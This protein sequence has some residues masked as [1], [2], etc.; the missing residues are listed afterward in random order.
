MTSQTHRITNRTKGRLLSEDVHAVDATFEHLT[1]LRVLIEGLADNHE[2]GLW[3]TDLKSIPSVPRISPIDLIYVDQQQRVVEAVELLPGGEEPA[4]KSPAVSALV[5]PF[6]TISATETRVGDQLLIDGAERATRAA[7]AEAAV[8]ERPASEVPVQG[9]AAGAFGERFE[10]LAADGRALPP[11]LLEA[12]A[13][14]PRA[15]AAQAMSGVAEADEMTVEVR[16]PIVSVPEPETAPERTLVSPVRQALTVHEVILPEEAP[17]AEEPPRPKG[18]RKRQKKQRSRKAR[19]QAAAQRNREAAAARQR[20]EQVE[21]ATAPGLPVPAPMLVPPAQITQPAEAAASTGAVTATRAQAGNETSQT[22][23]GSERGKIMAFVSRVLHWLNP[24]VINEEQ[25]GSIRR[26]AKDLVAYVGEKGAERKLEVDNISSSGVYVRTEERWEP[27]SEVTLS[28]QQNGPV[29]E[30]PDRHVRVEA[31]TVWHGKDGMGLKFK[32]PQGMQL[33]LWESAVSGDASQSGPDYIVH[34]MRIAQALGVVR[35]L[36]PQAAEPFRTMLRKDFSSVRVRD[37]IRVTHLVDKMLSHVAGRDGLTAPPALVLRILEM[38]SWASEEWT[39]QL[40]AGVLV[41]A[42]TPEG[43][44]ESNAELV[45]LLCQ[46]APVHLRILELASRRYDEAAANGATEA[47]PVTMH[48]LTKLLDLTNLTKTLRSVS[49]MAERGLMT[50]VKRPLADAQD[51]NAWSAVT[52]LGLRMVAR[53]KGQREG[54][55][56]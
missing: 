23:T 32:L 25:R 51:D 55:A 1:V 38:G 36:C 24:S 30:L 3:L 9:E 5:L 22:K 19:R 42:C 12:I 7:A 50:P 8:E 49:E 40:W 35:S 20:R 15:G 33:D 45:E 56:V 53:C 29:S 18:R 21:A 27:G 4:F 34:E 6:G 48:E 43:N 39:Q 54:R 10:T 47:P 16:P 31:S 52:P 41:S 28:L 26:P 44:D 11:A 46:L 14:A 13:Q 37:A 17:S 2:A